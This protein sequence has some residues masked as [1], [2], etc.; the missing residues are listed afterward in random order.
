M[1]SDVIQIPNRQ[2]G[3]AGLD[4]LPGPISRAG[5]KAAWRFVEFFTANIRNKNTRVA[6]AQTVSRFF[7]W[8]EEHRL[9][10]GQLQPVIIASYIE[11]LRASISAPSVKQHLAAI[12]ILFD[13]VI[14]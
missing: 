13:W 2:L 7:A 5:E 6:Y 9:G 3:R 8:C 14:L 10:L 4:S 11:G 12:R 1:T